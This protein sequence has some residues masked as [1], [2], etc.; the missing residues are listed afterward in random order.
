M[1]FGRDSGGSA[2]PF[3]RPAEVR[4]AAI[5]QKECPDGE[6]GVKGHERTRLP[7]EAADRAVGLR[8]LEHPLG[9]RSIAQSLCYL[10]IF[11]LGNVAE[12]GTVFVEM[13]VQSLLAAKSDAGQARIGAVVGWPGGRAARRRP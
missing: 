11:S 6:V 10:E 12:F 9:N 7:V 8:G 3:R 1:A 5:G 13:V 4:L 2:G